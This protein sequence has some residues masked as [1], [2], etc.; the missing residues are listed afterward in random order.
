MHTGRTCRLFFGSIL[1]PTQ[2]AEGKTDGE[3]DDPQQG[4]N[5]LCAI[6]SQDT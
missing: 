5:D 4:F 6:Y 3:I 2:E 1:I